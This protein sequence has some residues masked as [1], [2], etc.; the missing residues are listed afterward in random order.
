MLN[1]AGSSICVCG[2]WTVVVDVVVVMIDQGKIYSNPRR[3][4]KGKV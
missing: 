1:E 2:C 4:L 3:E